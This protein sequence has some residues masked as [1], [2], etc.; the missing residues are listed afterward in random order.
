MHGCMYR[1]FTLPRFIS[2]YNFLLCFKI[3]EAFLKTEVPGHITS[4]LVTTCLSYFVKIDQGLVQSRRGCCRQQKEMNLC[5][6]ITNLLTKWNQEAYVMPR[7]E[8]I[9]AFL[10]LLYLLMF[11]L[12]SYSLRAPQ[13]FRGCLVPGTFF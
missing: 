11:W 8:F 7:I 5:A 12:S 13:L 9:M 2:N 6:L 4:I 3:P 10:T 1:V